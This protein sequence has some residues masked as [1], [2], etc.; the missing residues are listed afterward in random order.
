[1]YLFYIAFV[2]TDTL[3]Y[4]TCHF[5]Y[6]YHYDLCFVF[7]MPHAICSETG[8]GACSVIALVLLPVGHGPNAGTF[9]QSARIQV[10]KLGV[11]VRR[12]RVPWVALADWSSSAGKE[13]RHVLHRRAAQAIYFGVFSTLL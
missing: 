12:L 4:H 8:Q 9:T 5:A 2:H 1:M 13:T 3:S 6:Y 11:H 10:S 7:P